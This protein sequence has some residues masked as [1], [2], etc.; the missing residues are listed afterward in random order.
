MHSNATA[1]KYA[2]DLAMT[3]PTSITG[4]IKIVPARSKVNTHDRKQVNTR[5]VKKAGGRRDPGSYQVHVE[6]EKVQHAAI[7]VLHKAFTEKFWQIDY[8][9]GAKDKLGNC[10][11]TEWGP[12]EIN[13]DNILEAIYEVTCIDGDDDFATS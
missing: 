7:E 5:L 9:D 10:L 11:V 6:F 12:P 3:S 4:L 2:S 13:E 1:I 8:S